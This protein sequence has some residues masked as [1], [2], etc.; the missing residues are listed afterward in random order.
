MRSGYRVTAIGAL[1]LGSACFSDPP[2]V[3]ADDDS[4]GTEPTVGHETGASATST[5]GAETTSTTGSGSNGPETSVGTDTSSADTTGASDTSGTETSSSTDD[6]GETQSNPDCVHRVFV[7]AETWAGDLG[8]LDGADEACTQLGE[9]LGSDWVAVLSTGAVNASQRVAIAGTVCDVNGQVISEQADE[10]WSDMHQA[11]I[12]VMADGETLPVASWR[13]WTGTDVGGQA[14]GAD[15]GGWTSS[16]LNGVTVGNANSSEGA[17]V[18]EMQGAIQ[19]CG[20]SGHLYC[21]SQPL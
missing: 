5:I 15:C 2:R 11:P 19:Q 14:T 8:G 7:T 6:A 20:F 13:V 12:N 1:I 17:W 16:V 10:W 4:A 18:N 9:G 21:M 3:G